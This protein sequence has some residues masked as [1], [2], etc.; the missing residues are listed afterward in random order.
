MDRR[1][2]NRRFR[3]SESSSE[4]HDDV[5]RDHQAADHGD[6]VGNRSPNPDKDTPPR[7]HADTD[8]EE[9]G[10]SSSER[11]GHEPSSRQVT[12]DDYYRS[13]K[14]KMCRSPEAA[15]E[16]AEKNEDEDEEEEDD[17]WGE[18]PAI[19]LED[20]FVLL[21]PKQRHQA[22]M[23]CRPWYEIFYSPRVWETFVLLERTLTRR[24]FNLYKGYQRELCPRKTQVCLMRVGCFFKRIVVTPI[25]DFY[26]LY[27]F[28]RV[29]AS[30]LGFY[31]DFPMP[32][33]HTFRFT[34]ACESRGMTGVVIHGTGGKILDEL[35]VLL[36]N[37]QQLRHLA[38][39]EL[40]LDVLEVPGLLEAAAKHSGDSLTSLEL[41]NCTKVPLAMPDVTQFCHLLKLKLS[42]QHLNDEVVLLLGGTQL[43]QL[44]LLQDAYTCPCEPVASE[45]WKLF[46]E[47]A[48]NKRVFL[49]IQGLTKTPLLL[50]PH[51]PVRG[52]V[53]RTPYHRLTADLCTW[54]VEYYSKYLEYFVQESLPRAHGSRK[55]HERADASF[56]RLIRTCHRLHTLVIRE[57]I[58]L[59][60]LLLIA[61]EGRALRT[62]IVRENALIK[63]CEWPRAREWSKEY[64]RWLKKTSRNYQL[65]FQEVPVVMEQ[66]WKPSP[67]RAFK[68]LRLLIS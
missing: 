50:Q 19:L 55:F 31:T 4:D 25:S 26:N 5:S 56:L 15:K 57:R 18:L 36:G 45:A 47:M 9:E 66:R 16:L 40:L 22:S 34:F 28:L 35:K 58:S 59:G 13:E 52:V 33:L 49:E 63:K 12:V 2:F 46:K 10:G 17:G 20:I 11:D 1:R 8:S 54:L 64:Y 51:A 41:L 53:F 6:D 39:N 3:F 42:P 29:L 37:M 48:P 68:H 23:V 38:L 67:D 61:S 44:H 43:L 24:R 21:T 30:F 27:E 32:L 7:G 60:T 14:L 65:A 62:F